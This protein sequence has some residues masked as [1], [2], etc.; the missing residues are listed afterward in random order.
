[1]LERIVGRVMGTEFGV[2]V[3]ENPDPYGFSHDRHSKLVVRT[4]GV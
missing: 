3:A 4:P 1:M 2:E